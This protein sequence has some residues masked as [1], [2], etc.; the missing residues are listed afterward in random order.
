MHNVKSNYKSECLPHSML[1]Y[2][3]RFFVATSK[4]Y[5]VWQISTKLIDHQSVLIFP[6]LI[7]RKYE[8]LCF[9]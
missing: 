9:K 1:F 6:E 7:L 2:L 8:F 3:C 4:G 5:E